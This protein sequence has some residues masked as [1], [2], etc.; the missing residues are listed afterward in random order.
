MLAHNGLLVVQQIGITT[1]AFPYRQYGE[2][3]EKATGNSSFHIQT[4][5]PSPDYWRIAVIETCETPPEL[6]LYGGASRGGRGRSV[7]GRT[8]CCGVGRR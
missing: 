7:S 2:E 8:R 5:V 1:V 4:M 6:L 3:Y